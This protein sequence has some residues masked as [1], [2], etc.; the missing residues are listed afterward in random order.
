MNKTIIINI[1]GTV[2]HIE[3]QA[4][5]V[6]KE[7]MT[8]VKRHFFN[9]ADSLEITTDIENRIAEMFS[10]ILAR[11]NRQALI[12]QDV[13]DVITQMGSVKDFETA[14]TDGPADAGFA[15][16]PFESTAGTR[17]L[18]RDADDHLIGGVCAGI[19]NY[20]DVQPAWVR[21]F[22]A[23]AFIFAGTGFILYIILWIIIPKAITRADRMAMKGEPLDLQGF[24]RN[25]EAEMSAVG[26]RLQAVG[27]DARPLA[28]K[29]RD[30]VSDFFHHLG[31]FLGG[32]GK[33]LIKVLGIALIMSCVAGI[34]TLIVGAIATSIFGI[35]FF[36]VPDIFISYN[37]ANQVIVAFA[38]LAIIPLVAIIMVVSSAVFNTTPI[39]R[40]VGV[41]LLVIWISS[42][43]VLLYHGSYAAAE[44]SESAGFSKTINL[45]P[46]ANQVYYLRLNE[47]HSLTAEDSARLDIEN[48]YKGL[49]L[50]ETDDSDLDLR[51]VRISIEK[52]D[53][54]YPVL[55]E[56]F[57]ARGRNYEAAL[58]NAHSTPYVFNQQDSVITFEAKL[59]RPHKRKWHNESLHITL[60]IP[61]NATVMVNERINRYLT[62]YINLNDCTGFDDTHTRDQYAPLVM[63]TEGLK[64]KFPKLK[65]NDIIEH[66]IPDADHTVLDTATTIMADTLLKTDTVFVDSI[67]SA[68][69]P[70]KKTVVVRRLHKK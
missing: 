21:L 50:T 38:L 33:V 69:A 5:E 67:I 46:T 16:P 68:P 30:F 17:R 36:E 29:T 9:S 13:Q 52:G 44:F 2:F 12:E 59:R 64:C 53:V 51:D 54:P 26:S 15:T 56:E 35:P 66:N 43:A 34:I 65:L 24:K 11:D 60:R 41:T 7:Y 22:F 6:L 70:R 1:N 61:V 57:S 28:Y 25:F 14:D 19:A 45:K 20:F 32:T 47:A 55:I 40:S 42:L 10:D 8:E 62:N 39:N 31:I 18:F 37:Y 58:E 3:E 4:Y 49:T 27:Q 23:L 48:K 63:T